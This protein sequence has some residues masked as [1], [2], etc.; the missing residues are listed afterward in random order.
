MTYAYSGPDRYAYDY[1]RPEE[2]NEPVRWYEPPEANEHG[3]T[4]YRHLGCRCA[5]CKRA[6]S[7]DAKRYRNKLKAKRPRRADDL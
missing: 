3:L 1:G 7:G 5:V 2:P 4:S 6:K